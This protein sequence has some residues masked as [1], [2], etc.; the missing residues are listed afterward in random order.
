MDTPTNTTE[1][2]KTPSA[3]DP[4]VLHIPRMNF[5]AGVL[6]LV[7]LIT[8][9]QTVQLFRINNTYASAPARSSENS[10]PAS[11]GAS[12][13]NANTPQSMVGGC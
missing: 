11:S 3:N 5:Q 1:E 4:I 8:V 6:G 13:G 12:N 7:A 2:P 9:F 10:A